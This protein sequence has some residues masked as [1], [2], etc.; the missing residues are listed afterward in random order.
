M[1]STIEEYEA[2]DVDKA[3]GDR[4]KTD[5]DVDPKTGEKRDRNEPEP[6]GE[7][8]GSGLRAHV[9]NAGQSFAGFLKKNQT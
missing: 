7:G 6:S 4:E 5:M 9:G 2:M 1:H 3:G 8:D